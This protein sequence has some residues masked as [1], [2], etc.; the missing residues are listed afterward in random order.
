MPQ[1]AFDT[2]AEVGK[3]KRAGWPEEQAEAMVDLVVRAPLNPQLAQDMEWLKVHV[4]GIENRLQGIETRVK[5]I[6]TSVERTETRI[7]RIE[8]RV[9][10]VE[11][12]VLRTDDAMSGMAT[13]VDLEVLR[14]E[15]MTSIEALRGETTTRIEALRSE[16]LRAFWIQGLAL[17]S[18]IIGLAGTMLAVNV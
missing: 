2:H 15:T 8:T 1:A 9:Q 17:A 7:Q 5:G 12:H 11:T 6:E 4:Q 3:L 13:S 18:L 16:M 14:G 10:G